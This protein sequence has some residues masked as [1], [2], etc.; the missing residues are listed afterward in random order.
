MMFVSWRVQTFFLLGMNFV[1]IGVFVD[2][3]RHRRNY[4]GLLSS[5]FVIRMI[6]QLI[7][8][9]ALLSSRKSAAIRALAAVG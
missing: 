6:L 2:R 5:G 9:V 3:E 8:G 7:G 1:R 4:L